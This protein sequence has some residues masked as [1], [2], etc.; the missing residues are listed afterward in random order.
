MD[1]E[2]LVGEPIGQQLTNC[3][4]LT[5]EYADIDKRIVRQMDEV[6]PIYGTDVVTF[7]N[8]W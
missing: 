4:S 7:S 6:I 5:L 8:L 2:I 3:E 1:E